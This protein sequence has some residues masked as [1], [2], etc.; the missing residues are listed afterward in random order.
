[1]LFIGSSFNYII[2][3]NK[4]KEYIYKW[5]CCFETKKQRDMWVVSLCVLVLVYTVRGM[6]FRNYT[7]CNIKQKRLE[8]KIF[9]REV[10]S[11]DGRGHHV[12]LSLSFRKTCLCGELNSL[13]VNNDQYIESETME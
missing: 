6:I 4:I 10:G 1:M 5:C 3:I 13:I 12:S 7:N 11:L 8:G 2:Y 9:T